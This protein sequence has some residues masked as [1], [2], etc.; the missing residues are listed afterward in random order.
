[1]QSKLKIARLLMM[2]ASGISL[3]V[4]LSAS[5]SGSEGGPASQSN[6]TALY[7]KGKGVYADKVG[8]SGCPLAGKT[9][10]VMLAKDLLAGN[11]KVALN[12]AEQE[13]LAVYLK[14]RFKLERMS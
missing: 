5:A 9:L 13:A 4:P 8:C 10:D 2:I 14:R 12:A 3:A 7:N 1:M 11:P 6:E